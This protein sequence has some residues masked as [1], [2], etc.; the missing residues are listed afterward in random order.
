M[1]TCNKQIHQHLSA[2]RLLPSDRKLFKQHLSIVSWC[3][4]SLGMASCNFLNVAAFGMMQKQTRKAKQAT[5]IQT[6]Q[7]NTSGRR[8][9]KT[10]KNEMNKTIFINVIATYPQKLVAA[11]KTHRI[12]PGLDFLFCSLFWI[13]YRLL[14]RWWDPFHGDKLTLTWDSPKN[15]GPGSTLTPGLRWWLRWW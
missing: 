14:R 9:R 2:P 11:K 10:T 4:L 12:N 6:T 15:G 3:V 8:R 5:K 1:A 13:C 7:N